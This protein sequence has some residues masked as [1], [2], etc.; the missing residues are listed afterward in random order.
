MRSAGFL[1][2][3]GALLAEAGSRQAKVM[4]SESLWRC[5]RRRLLADVVSVA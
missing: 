5:S 4:R 2:A 1:D 3:F